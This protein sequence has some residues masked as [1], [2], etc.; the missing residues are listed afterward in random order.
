[1]INDRFK[2]IR[3]LG[4]GRSKVFF[5]EDIFRKET[6]LAIKILP[7]GVN[8]EEQ[9]SFRDEFYLLNKLN[10]P[11]IIKVFE[12]GTIVSLDDEEIEFQIS[13]GSKFFILEYFE[14]NE[15]YD[16]PGIKDESQLLKII[17]QISSVLYYLHQSAFI[18]YD[19]KSENILVRNIN[20]RPV[21]KFID[22]GLASQIREDS[23]TAKGTAEYIAP[24]ILRKDKVD[25][26]V[27][28]YSLGILLY[29]IIYGKFPFSVKDQ[30]GIYK[31]H[32]DEQFKFPDSP[33][34]HKLANLTK[35]LLSKEIEQRYFTSIGILEE[36]D[37]SNIKNYKNDWTRI[38]VFAGRT[39]SLS[40]ISA[41]LEKE[42]K[43]EVF[44]VKG[45]EGAGKTML[46]NE[47]NYKYKNSI[48]I[49]DEQNSEPYL[50]QLMLRRVLYKENIFV[51]LND[52]AIQKGKKILEGNS[53][54]LI[55][56]LKALFI[57]LSSTNEFILLID[58]FNLLSNFDL[59]IFMRLIPVLQ[60][61]KI[62]IVIA[63]DS[64]GE[65]RSEKINNT[66]K[67]NLNPFTESQVTEFI[68]KS[69]AQFYPK[70]EIRKT[71]IIYSDLLP[72]SIEI[73]LKDLIVLNLLEFLADSPVMNVGDDF[74]S[75]LKSSQEEIYQ[76]R[77]NDLAKENRDFAFFLSM[78]NVSLDVYSISGLT[79]KTK[80]QI[81][82]I[83]ERLSEANIIHQSTILNNPQF[84][85]QGIKEF[86]YSTIENKKL[87]HLKISDIILERLPS[88]DRN[89]LARHLELAGEFEKS[90]EVLK[91][92]IEKADKASALSY[93]KNLLQHL[94]NL[95]L[96]N[97]S[98]RNVKIELSHCLFQ[99][100]ELNASINLINELLENPRSQEEELSL[101]ILKGKALI[102]S[103]SL[104]EG[105]N[106]L[107]SVLVF[108][109]KN[110]T[111][112][113]V[114]AKISEAD[115]HLA[116][117]NEAERI[118]DIILKDPSASASTKGN[119]YLVKGLIQFF[120][121]NDPAMTI[122]YFEESLKLFQAEYQLDKVASMENNIANIYHILRNKEKAELH[123]NKALQLNSSI[124]D[125]QQ[126]GAILINYGIYYFNN[127]F[128]DLAVEEYN[129]ARNILQAFGDKNYLGFTFTNLGEVL[130]LLCEYD[131][132]ITSL[133][134]SINLF[135]DIAMIYEKCE[136]LFILGKVYYE[137]GHKE[138]FMQVVRDFEKNYKLENPQKLFDKHQ[139]LI[140]L[141]E[142]FNNNFIKDTTIL[143]ET[144]NKLRDNSD[145]FN[146]CNLEILLIENFIF[147]K[148][149]DYALAELNNPD[150][151]EISNDN[152]Y[153]KAYRNFLTGKI[154]EISTSSEL[155]PAINY[156][157]K[158]Y[159]GIKELSITELTLQILQSLYES[160][161]NRG[162]A[163]KKEEYAKYLNYL[164]QLI[165]SQ[166]K[167]NE[168]RN[169]YFK[170]KKIIEILNMINQK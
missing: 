39:D 161:N 28:L 119:V 110:K 47:L 165:S 7:A 138:R 152:T 9:K 143:Y 83:L 140:L 71:I 150:F 166:I 65:Y 78:F 53:T 159:E 145:S 64:I 157:N 34:S 156:Y 33:Y 115:Y 58:D 85:S 108:I 99:L 132:A 144:R 120:N 5:C 56:E 14:G 122:N 17:C 60:V 104:E 169:L 147:L 92:E 130:L 168:L 29:K 87:A 154:S 107:E 118:S 142:L 123:W 127:C 13:T 6:D 151:L 139:Y 126:Q 3:I 45:S 21:I 63:E 124:G 10:H 135:N 112:N 44:I 31:A 41:Y 19:L 2:I 80:E 94:M 40:V 35:R 18:Y 55:E 153:F 26:R 66:Q 134:Q 164:L 97:D 155:E 100:G 72:G 114:L 136:A 11:N 111:K 91:E 148:K 170:R 98:K 52:E 32:I 96:N 4:Q 88:F 89:E 15:I 74:D 79:G 103:K 162:Y 146:Y 82:S 128:Y 69:F 51:N 48:L 67:I 167:D 81:I 1:M 12:F 25:H 43:G 54:N 8:K 57:I 73:F 163:K 90:Y 76:L 160:Y 75:I 137:L 70:N 106:L 84:T 158:A 105:K 42:N 149:Y 30:L 141:L 129:K 61:G 49:S 46:M 68:N 27:D 113:E 93:K 95:P 23:L 102:D 86:V 20:G 116:K 77:L 38:P 121:Y 101:K 36:F 37:P 125:V 16:F 109:K 22:F 117:Y 24:E 50:W 62:K 131:K 59:E 133:N